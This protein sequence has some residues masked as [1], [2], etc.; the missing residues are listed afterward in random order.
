MTQTVVSV[1][2]PVQ[3]SLEI[4]KNRI[5]PA[6]ERDSGKRICVITGIHG[7]ELEGQ[8][9]AYRLNRALA[10]HPE[11]LTATVDIYPAIN[12]LGIN[13]IT[14]GIPLFDLDMNRVF[15]G[16]PNGA[17][18][19]HIACEVVEDIKGADIAIDVHASNI[20]LTELP[21]VRISEET[22]P[23]LVP[24]AR[25]LNIDFIWVH[26]AATVLESTLAHSLNSAGTDCLVVEMG[27]GMRL[28]RSYGD[29]LLDGILNLMRT[30]GMWLGETPKP[31]EPIIG[32]DEVA[33][34]NADAAGIFIPEVRHN[35]MVEKGQ[36]LGVVADPLTGQDKELVTAP[37]A[38]LLFTLRDYPVVYPGS[39]LG[40]ILTGGFER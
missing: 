9:L 3:E 13:S 18:V 11:L 7:D 21:Q 24:L 5:T 20:F 4:Q 29:Q 2:L 31:R 33:F 16:D 19:E 15:P 34:L 8:Y 38:G 30:Q 39:L 35:H 32:R 17:M 37:E 40:R 14:R 25:E 26:A 1:Q 36:L 27:V 28:T 10:A 12:P 22:A 23:R 6:P